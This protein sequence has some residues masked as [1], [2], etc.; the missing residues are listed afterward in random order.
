MADEIPKK[1]TSPD[2][3]A[4]AIR[5]VFDD[6]TPGSVSSWLSV[7]HQGVATYLT[8]AQVKDWADV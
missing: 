4:V 5:T 6:D 1:K 2:G 7:N 3:S 8:E